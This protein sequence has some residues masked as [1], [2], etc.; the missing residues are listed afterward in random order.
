MTYAVRLSAENTIEA[1]IVAS[2]DPSDPDPIDLE[3]TTG[4]RLVRVMFL[5]MYLATASSQ[6]TSMALSSGDI[7]IPPPRARARCVLSSNRALLHIPSPGSHL[8]TCMN[9]ELF[10]LSVAIR[11]AS[12]VAATWPGET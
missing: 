9:A 4:P 1:A 11:L 12:P 2:L 6:A 10:A 8:M 5:T 3:A 7:A